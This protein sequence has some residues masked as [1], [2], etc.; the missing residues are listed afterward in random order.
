MLSV[1]VFRTGNAAFCL[2]FRRDYDAFSEH[3]GSAGGSLDAP[4]ILPCGSV[5]SLPS[6]SGLDRIASRCRGHIECPPV[7]KNGPA[8]V[9]TTP[10]EPGQRAGTTTV[11]PALCKPVSVP[12]RSALVFAALVQS[13]RTSQIALAL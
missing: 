10:A 12:K 3:L 9:V 2:D 5:Y 13:L 1:P 11:K 4:E 6:A 7:G 8:Y